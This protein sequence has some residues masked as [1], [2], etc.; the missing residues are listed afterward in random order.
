MFNEDSKIDIILKN[1]D[2]CAKA[3]FGK[4]NELYSSRCESAPLQPL[5]EDFEISKKFVYCTVDE[6]LKL[7]RH[8]WENLRP[9]NQLVHSSKVGE[10][11]TEQ[12]ISPNKHEGMRIL[13]EITDKSLVSYREFEKV[14]L[15]SIL[16]SALLNLASVLNYGE[17]GVSDASL[18]LKLSNYERNF[19]IKGTSPDGEYKQGKHILQAVSKYQAKQPGCSRNR[20]TE[21]IQKTVEFTENSNKE[22]LKGYLFKLKNRAREFVNDRG[23]IMT[24]LRNTWEISNVITDKYKKTVSTVLDGEQTFDQQKYFKEIT[25]VKK[26]R[27]D[28]APVPRKIKA[29]RENY[30]LERYQKLIE[31]PLFK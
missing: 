8:W 7:L 20:V 13:K 29:F 21:N 22:R 3:L 12:N 17:L 23:D 27:H 25:K 11:L 16:K 5:R 9:V 24:N 10:F 4:N 30:T 14:F 2:I 18:R 28:K 26:S 31:S 19:M 1:L 6:Y 15:K